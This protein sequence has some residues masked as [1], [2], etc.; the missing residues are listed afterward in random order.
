MRA[1]DLLV[2]SLALTGVPRLFTL[3]GNQIM[4]VFDA[5]LDEGLDPIHVR[6]EAAAVHMADAWGRL[7]GQPGIALVTAAPGF[8]NALTALYVALMAE[9]PVVLVSGASPHSRA[10]QGAFQERPQAEMAGFVTKA[11]WQITDPA[12]VGHDIARAYRM[13]QSGRPGPVHLSIPGDV[14]SAAVDR[15]A[16]AMPQPDDFHPMIT[17]LETITAETIVEKLTTADRP[18]ILGGAALTR[19]NGPDQMQRLAE[20]LNIP[21]VAMESPRGL[22]DP[23]LGRLRDSLQ[24][25]DAVALIGRPL[26]FGISFGEQP[27]FRGDCEFLL[28][29][30]EMRFIEQAGKKI[31][32]SA[33]IPITALADPFPSVERLLQVAGNKSNGNSDWRNEVETAIRSRPHDWETVTS[34]SDGPIRPAELCRTVQRFL[35]VGEETVYIADGGEFGQWAQACLAAQHRVINGPSGCIGGAIP[36]AMAARLAFPDARIVALLG[37]GTFG[38]LPLEFDTAVRYKLPFVVVVGN[39][40]R[41][42]AEYQI[43]LR[44][45]GTERLVGCELLPTRY[46]AVVKAL[47]GHG[48]N[49]TQPSELNVAFQRAF[50]SGKPA[51]VNVAIAGLAAPE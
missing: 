8:T 43:Q 32:D 14:L 34:P 28:I 11:S 31:A 38:F 27:A 23:S 20:R 35:P 13:A 24:R 1:A 6:H 22:K 21:A 41:W 33:R 48:E 49:V 47:G 19:G 17:P 50:D 29:D 15:P 18:M 16:Q 40:A 37:D 3:S 12:Q 25:A 46:D 9:S 36:F 30:P 42:N 7:T 39:D 26:N 10:G 51:C 44:D 2:R 4:S 5:C 45:Y